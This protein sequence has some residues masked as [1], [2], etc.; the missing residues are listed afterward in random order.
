MLS[1]TIYIDPLTTDASPGEEDEEFEDEYVKE[2]E[3]R[4]E[5]RPDKDVKIS[6]KY[7]VIGTV[8]DGKVTSL[9]PSFTI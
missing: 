5:N 1:D 7:E 8:L 9:N 2:E 6:R 4:K 3:K